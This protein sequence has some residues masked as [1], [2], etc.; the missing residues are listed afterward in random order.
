MPIRLDHLQGKKLCVVFMQDTEE[1]DPESVK[2]RTLHG[3][4]DIGRNG[5]LI[6]RNRTDAFTVP[7]SA[8]NMVLPND[9]TPLLQDAEYFVILKVSGMEL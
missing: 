9:G 3:R 8:Y 2:L 7:S 5:E 6:V 4:A 1:E